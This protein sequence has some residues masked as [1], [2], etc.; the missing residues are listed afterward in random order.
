MQSGRPCQTAALDDG[1]CLMGAGFCRAATPTPMPNSSPICAT[2]RLRPKRR[3]KATPQSVPEADRP[4]S[5]MINR[6]AESLHAWLHSI[7][8]QSRAGCLESAPAHFDGRRDKRVL[9]DKDASN[10]LCQILACRRHAIGPV[11][12]RAR[13]SNPRAERLLVPPPVAGRFTSAEHFRGQAR[14]A[15]TSS[16]SSISPPH[17]TH[18]LSIIS[19]G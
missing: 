17:D 5:V 18:A 8:R 14:R 10:V 1:C 4:S 3:A 11:N 6:L 15:N 13:S 7:L 19:P 16:L 9:G 2:G 12:V